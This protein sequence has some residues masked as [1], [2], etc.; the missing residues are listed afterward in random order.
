MKTL[1]LSGQSRRL[2]ELCL[3]VELLPSVSRII[4]IHSIGHLKSVPEIQFA[5]KQIF[6]RRICNL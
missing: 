2:I 3:T 4:H 5:R 6:Q 1:L